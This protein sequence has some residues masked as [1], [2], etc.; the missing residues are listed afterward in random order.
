MKILK[1]LEFLEVGSSVYIF[2]AYLDTRLNDFDN[3]RY[4]TFIRMMAVVK[5]R[6]RPSLIC[7]FSVNGDIRQ[8]NVT[9]YEMCENHNRPYGG[10]ILSCLVPVDLTSP[11]CSVV[12]ATKDE[13]SEAEVRIRTLKPVAE[14]RN[15]TICV[16]PVFGRVNI[17]H[18]VEFLE[19]SFRIG[20]EHVVLY[21]SGRDPDLAK[22]LHNYVEVKK[23]VSVIP[24][25][26]KQH[27]NN[28]FIWYHGQL[29][30]IQDCLYRHMATSNYISFNDLDEF[31]VPHSA[32]HWAD[33]V[34]EVGSITYLWLSVFHCLFQ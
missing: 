26:L 24:W 1:E 30:A 17:Q 28:N 16:P 12:V 21:I 22:I 11:I 29:V 31:I 5:V 27:M 4:R 13:D 20:A 23:Q 10:F 6:T 14:R 19:V 33:M 9:Y 34:D 2:S 32:A 7:K 3:P 18:L 8:S 25:T 15:F